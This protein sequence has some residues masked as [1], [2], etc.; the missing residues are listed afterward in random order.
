MWEWL[1]VFW[2]ILILKWYSDNKFIGILKKE[3]E[4]SLKMASNRN[5]KN[6]IETAK[7]ALKYSKVAYKKK[8]SNVTTFIKMFLMMLG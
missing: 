6:T 1:L 7:L 2:L 8:E 3:F 5:E 4:K